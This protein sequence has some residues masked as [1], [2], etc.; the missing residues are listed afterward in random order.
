[1]IIIPA[2][3]IL[4]GKCV[5]LR[6]GDFDSQKVYAEKP[7][8]MAKTFEKAGIEYLHLVDLDGARSGKVMNW[9]VVKSITENTSLKVDFGGGIKTPDDI[10]RLFQMRVD[11]INLGSIAY[12][13]PNKVKDWLQK[14]GSKKIILSADCKDE[15]LAVAGWQSQT[16]IAIIN[17]IMEYALAGLEY[18]TCTDISKDGML[19]GPNIVLY[20]KILTMVTSIKLIA[21]GGISSKDD[22]NALASAGCYGAIVGKAFYEGKITIKEL[23]S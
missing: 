21:S 12:N 2:I 1:M 7:L 18:V 16:S 15:M 23:R 22:L 5:R 14:Y 13:Q 8:D 10:E 11:K 19:S 20:K 3:D 9:K 17:Y 4:N 6:Q